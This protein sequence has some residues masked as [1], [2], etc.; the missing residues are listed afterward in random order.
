MKFIEAYDAVLR[1]AAKIFEVCGMAAMVILMI[2]LGSQAVCTLMGISLLWSDEICFLMSYW[3]IFIGASVL[4]YEKKH[5]MVDALVKLFPHGL[6]KAVAVLEK[7]LCIAV[8]AVV[9]YATVIYL[10]STK[11]VTTIVLHMP[12]IVYYI[13]PAM[14]FLY[15]VLVLVRQLIEVMTGTE[16]EDGI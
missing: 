12:K 8:S 15:F 6:R 4:M 5:V 9:L 1:K 16:G 3:I 13:V 2:T 10:N 7:V 11:N 14:A